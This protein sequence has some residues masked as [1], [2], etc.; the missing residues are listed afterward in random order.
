MQSRRVSGHLAEGREPQQLE[1]LRRAE[2]ACAVVLWL[3][4]PRARAIRDPCVCTC[5]VVRA[6]TCKEESEDWLCAERALSPSVCVHSSL[7]RAARMQTMREGEQ[8][9]VLWPP[10]VLEV[11]EVPAEGLVVEKPGLGKVCSAGTAWVIYGCEAGGGTRRAHGA[12]SLDWR[13]FARTRARPR[14]ERWKPRYEL[15]SARGKVLA[16]LLSDSLSRQMLPHEKENASIPYRVGVQS[17]PGCSS[18]S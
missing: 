13:A 10:P 5:A 16:P 3:C 8:R 11:A 12:S 7:I 1:H 2:Q 15:T 4:G 18:P 17:E 9:R 6:R 14:A